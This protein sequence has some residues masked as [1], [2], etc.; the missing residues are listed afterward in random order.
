[1]KIRSIPNSLNV[2]SLNWARGFP[3]GFSGPRSPSAAKAEILLISDDTSLGEHLR[4]AAG[5]AGRVVV[6][7]DGVID[8]LRKVLAGQL[9][10]VLLDLDLPAEAAWETAD[11]LLQEQSCPPL[12][13]LTARSDQFDLSTAI[14]AGSLV[15]KTTDPSRLLGVVADTLAAPCSAQAERNAIQRV[16][17]QWLKPCG[18]SAPIKPAH[19]IGGIKE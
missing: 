14:R 19:R 10:A 12:I 16:M 1:M 17:I 11:C 6:Q 4:C 5:R 7:V 2:A 3:R 9:V 13:L 15:D 18:W 8:A